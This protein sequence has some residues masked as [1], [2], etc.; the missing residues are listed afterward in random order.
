MGILDILTVIGVVLFGT[1]GGVLL[2]SSIVQLKLADDLCEKAESLIGV[3]I[4]A[5]FFLMGIISIIYFIIEA[6]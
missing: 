4:G 1:I 2:Y 5:L 3:V 6:M